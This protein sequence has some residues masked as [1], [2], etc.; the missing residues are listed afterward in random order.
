MDYYLKSLIFFRFFHRLILEAPAITD[1]AIQ[2]L[3]KYCTDKVRVEQISLN[4]QI[5]LLFIKR[6]WCL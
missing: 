1:N 6:C 3:K 2:I 4:L 5:T